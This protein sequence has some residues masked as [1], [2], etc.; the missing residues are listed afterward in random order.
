MFVSC[1]ALR[2]LQNSGGHFHVLCL[3]I[4]TSL[5]EP[6]VSM[7][8]AYNYSRVT[9]RKLQFEYRQR[10]HLACHWA[11][12]LS[13]FKDVLMS[14]PKSDP[15][16]GGCYT[17]SIGDSRVSQDFRFAWFQRQSSLQ[18]WNGSVISQ[19][20]QKV[21]LSQ[22][23]RL[24]EGRAAAQW[25]PRCSLQYSMFVYGNQLDNECH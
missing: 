19:L 22:F 11:A 25:Q 18:L 14:I 15:L 6:R 23:P 7:S 10:L 9:V 12:A 4:W 24:S 13:Y 16:G 20:W 1:V 8:L 21:L 5:T 3:S 2:D 17:V